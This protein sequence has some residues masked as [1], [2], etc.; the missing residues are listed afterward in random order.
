MQSS[1]KSV[2]VKDRFDVFSVCSILM[3]VSV[4]CFVFIITQT[5]SD[6]AHKDTIGGVI[7]VCG[8]ILL[9]MSISSINVDKTPFY[10]CNLFMILFWGIC[11]V[12]SSDEMNTGEYFITNDV[13]VG[14][15]LDV[16]KAEA[17]FNLMEE[18]YDVVLSQP[19]NYQLIVDSL[20][21][22]TNVSADSNLAYVKMQDEIIA[23]NNAVYQSHAELVNFKDYLKSTNVGVYNMFDA[24]INE[25]IK[26]F[27]SLTMVNDIYLSYIGKEKIVYAVFALWIL[28]NITVFVLLKKDK[29]S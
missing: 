18:K 13:A 9:C 28:L 20:T 16:Y 14:Y 4:L 15:I 23:F 29:S 12:V 10:L 5:G 24:Q 22:V 11:F 2:E 3:F 26:T 17:L 25:A 1:V 19:L 8:F 21:N 27:N 7:A 6:T